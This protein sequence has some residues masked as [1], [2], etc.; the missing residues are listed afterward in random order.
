MKYTTV[1][2]VHVYSSLLTALLGSEEAAT[3]ALAARTLQRLGN[4]KFNS[5]PL[6][7]KLNA[8][9][10]RRLERARRCLPAAHDPRVPVLP[11][12][13]TYPSHSLRL[14]NQC[15]A[16]QALEQYHGTRQPLQKR[17]PCHPKHITQRV[18]GILSWLEP[19]GPL[20]QH[21]GM[22]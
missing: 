22:T 4:A 20:V 17:R 13:A 21:R 15:V 5:A 2:R 12:P 3:E 18:S 14:I 9:G 7:S 6:H 8:C 10:Q 16:W 11:C 19:Q 1:L